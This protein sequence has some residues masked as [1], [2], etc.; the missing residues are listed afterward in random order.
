M[1]NLNCFSDFF[2]EGDQLAA[3]SMS[4]SSYDCPLCNFSAPTRTLWLSHIRS[5]H[6][7]DENF[8][9]I[10]GINQCGSK[11][12][13]CA[14]FVTHIYRQHRDV[15]CIETPSSS[16]CPPS[17][18]SDITEVLSSNSTLDLECIYEN[19]PGRT[20]LQHAVDQILEKDEE[21]Q[22]KKEAL[23]ILNLKE[24][25]GLSEA[26]VDHI[27]GETSKM[28]RHSLGRIEAGVN[29]RLA[30]NGVDPNDLP[31]LQNFFS[32]VKYPFQHLHSTYLQEKFY[33]QEFGCIVSGCCITKKNVPWI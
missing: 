19:S 14:S 17:I 13:K 3:V 24:V 6:S 21:V 12:N 10:C 20:A 5:V 2:L 9:I 29:D 32:S 8:F 31:D 23:F 33:H 30:K 16:T 4:A 27:L 26:A 25:R 22:E 18:V 1:R 11:Y 15:L 28:F 7:G